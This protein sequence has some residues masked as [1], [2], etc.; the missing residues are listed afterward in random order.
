MIQPQI[1]K[2][3]EVMNTKGYRVYNTPENEW[4]INIVGVRNRNN[5]PDKFDDTL[6]VFH[7]FMNNWFVSYYPITTDPSISYL[8]N[9]LPEVAHKGTAILKEGQYLSAYK[10]DLH[11]NNYYA[12]CQRLEKVSVFRDNNRNGN[13]NFN[14]LTV[15]TDMF[16]IN[17][18][19]GP[20]NGNWDSQN[21]N[22]S[23]GCQVF[24]D[25]RHFNE[26]M[27][28]CRNGERKFGNKFTYTL[29]NEKDFD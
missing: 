9:P 8:Q 12:L 6:I 7:N 21:I 22:Y 23:A 5:I 18:H 15:E 1:E 14:P 3:L 19:K 26:F 13:L 10:I 4:N 29:L 2:I 28:K 16:A 11:Q 27:Q 20:R 25:T 17:I 24:A